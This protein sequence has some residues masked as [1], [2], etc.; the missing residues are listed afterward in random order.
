MLTQQDRDIR[1]KEIKE[2]EEKLKLQRKHEEK[3]RWWAGVEVCH[4]ECNVHDAALDN[5]VS[6]INNNHSEEVDKSSL[7][8]IRKRYTAD[9]SHWNEW[10]PTDEAS[11]AEIEESKANE[12]LKRN[13]EFEK[14]NS[15]FCSQFL[16]D[17]E[18]RKKKTT[19]KQE[20]ADT[21]RLKG[22]R[23]F[24][25]KAYVKALEQYMDALKESPFDPKT[26]NNIAQVGIDRIL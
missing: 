11:I 9:Y 17:M 24:K 12:E 1:L 22:N 25:A 5:S 8:I 6:H 3:E 21:L 26:L 4:P 19:K 10:V 7:A 13:Q 20:N 23:Y 16:S 15:E 2:K 14:N 18:E